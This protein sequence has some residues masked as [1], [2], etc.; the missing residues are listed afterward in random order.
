MVT[1]AEVL[2][3]LRAVCLA[4]PGASE[5]VTWGH[6]TFK[7]N[8][9]TF[10][11]LEEYK[12]VLGICMKVEKELQDIFLKDE[13]FFLTPYIGKQGWI[14]LRVHGARLNW[15]EISELIKGSYLLVDKKKPAA[16]RS[17]KR[18]RPSE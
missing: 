3:K 1:E 11:V 13:R 12:G 18:K 2:K 16:S 5:T 15:R 14:T 8:G 9:K 4:L 17:S 10:S 7:V 6:P